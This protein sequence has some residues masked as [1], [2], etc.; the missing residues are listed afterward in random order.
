MA[1]AVKH[2]TTWWVGIQHLLSRTYPR[3]VAKYIWGNLQSPK[4]WKQELPNLGFLYYFCGCCLSWLLQSWVGT[5][6][7]V[8]FPWLCCQ[9]RKEDAMRLP[10]QLWFWRT[11]TSSSVWF[12]TVALNLSTEGLWVK[13]HSAFTEKKIYKKQLKK[14]FQEDFSRSTCAEN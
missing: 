1:N 4:S 13:H 11:Q 7:C 14:K 8:I 12:F 5:G 9:C 2:P 3:I 6:F 10:R